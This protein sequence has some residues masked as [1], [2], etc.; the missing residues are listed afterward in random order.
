MLC[1]V[2]APELSRKSQVSQAAWEV[3]LKR[4]PVLHI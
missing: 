3:D 2:V 4:K 1:I